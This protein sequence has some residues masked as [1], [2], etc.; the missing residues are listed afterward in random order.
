MIAVKK[1]DQ[2]KRLQGKTVLIRYR[3]GDR[4]VTIKF[5]IDDRHVSI[6]SG[7]I[8]FIEFIELV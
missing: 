7:E 4:V 1:I 2:L 5:V 3:G 6:T 8:L